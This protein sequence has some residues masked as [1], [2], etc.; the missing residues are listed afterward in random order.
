MLELAARPRA[1]SAGEFGGSGLHRRRAYTPARA[2]SSATASGDERWPLRIIGRYATDEHR[3]VPR[4]PLPLAEPA[5]PRAAAHA[6]RTS[7]AKRLRRQVGQA[8]ADFGMIEDGDK[9]MVC[10]SGGK[11]SYTMLD[12]LLQLQREGAGAASS[13]SR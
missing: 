11:D 13:W 8:I 2:A 10:L 1:G 9:V 6:S 7:S 4:Q 12:I 5:S 3:P